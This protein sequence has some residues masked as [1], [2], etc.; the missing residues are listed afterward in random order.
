MKDFW[1][2]H[3]QRLCDSIIA[4]TERARAGSKHSVIKGSSIEFVLRR[5]LREYLPEDLEVG[6][7]QI[8]SN[9]GNISPQIDVLIYEAKTF[10]RLAVNE[11]SSVVVCCES[12]FAA[13]ECKASWSKGQIL[14]NFEGFIKVD[15]ERHGYFNQRDLFGGYFALIVDGMRPRSFSP[16]EDKRRFVGFYTLKGG[17]S[18]R[19]KYDERCF[20]KHDGNAL[21]ALLSDMMHDCMRKDLKEL[22]THTLTWQTV[23]TYAQ[24][25]NH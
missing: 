12:V 9:T 17:K 23:R 10:P 14:S 7:G 16:F 21:E 19:S 6:T 13:V 20:E 8:A 11:D 18:W 4:Q 1:R 22:G 15:L 24:W 3:L 5:T 2:K 25:Q